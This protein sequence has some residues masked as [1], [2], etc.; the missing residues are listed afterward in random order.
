MTEIQKVIQQALAQYR[1]LRRTRAWL[2]FFG[3]LALVIML[4]ALLDRMWMFSGWARWSGWIAGLVIAAWAARRAAGPACPDASALAH[5][6]E[7]EAGETAPVV[8]TAIDPAVRQTADREELARVFL[9]RLDRRAAAAIRLAPPTFQGRL[10]APVVLVAVAAAALTALV[11]LQGGQGL[12][13]ML[14]PW[15]PSPYTSLALEGPAAPVAEGQAFTLT[16]R[17]SGVPVEKVT[18]YR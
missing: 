11:A 1:G 9:G 15:Q 7:A 18:L 5:R 6:V 8:A 14:L 16:A 4:A 17:V 13:R 10:R 3:T 2:V 12:L